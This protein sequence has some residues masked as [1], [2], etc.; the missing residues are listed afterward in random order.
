MRAH[1]E[2]FAR[3]VLPAI[4][5]LIAQK[6][7]KEMGLKQSE[8]AKL[9]G[10]TQATISHYINFRR[11]KVTKLLQTKEVASS[12]DEVAARIV[13]ERA[14]I[15]PDDLCQICRKAR[16]HLAASGGARASRRQPKSPQ[17]PSRP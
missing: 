15:T 5:A 7:V 3:E 1:C 2:T 9:L 6:L 14:S 12:L 13:K 16:M 8:A 11:G 17:Q 10:V 4:R